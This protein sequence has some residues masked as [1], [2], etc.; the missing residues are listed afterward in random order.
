M[1]NF[2]Q[3]KEVPKSFGGSELKK[4]MLYRD[5]IYMVKFPDPVREE[6]NQLSYMNN[7]FSEHAGCEI[8]KMCGIA[9]QETHL[10]TFTV[11]NKDKVVV[12]CKDFTN[13]Y[14]ELIEFSSIARANVESEKKVTTAIETVYDVI[15][16]SNLIEEKADTIEKFWDMFVVDALIG[17]TDRHL[18][19]WGLTNYN[20]DGRLTFAPVYDC[21]SSLSALVS[22]EN[23]RKFLQNETEFKNNEYNIYSVYTKEGKRILYHEI[24]KS[25]TNDL[26]KAIERIVPRIEIN[27]INKMIRNIEGMPDVH[28]EYMTKSL[29]LRNNLILQPSLK[30]IR[31][32]NLEPQT[33]DS[34]LEKVKSSCST[35]SKKATRNIR[36]DR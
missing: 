22:D 26:T 16:N 7:Q 21:G 30:R 20:G 34:L 2:N 31:K 33:I 1:I 29:E 3:A 19:N 18:T 8:F 35:K 12:A 4:A 17:N 36:E 5:D 10:G 15:Q 28:K 27:A 11:G 24:F 6:K 32:Q 9:V 14:G 25:P 13:E 23:K